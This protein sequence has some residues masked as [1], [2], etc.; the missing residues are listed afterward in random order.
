MYRIFLFVFITILPL[1][2]F[3]EGDYLSRRDGFL[4]IWSSIRRSCDNGANQ[5]FS[6][7]K[8][9][10]QGYEEISYA[11]SRG[12]LDDVEMFDPDSYLNMEDAL[13]WLFR[14]RNVRDDLFF[15][16]RQNIGGM[17]GEYP[18]TEFRD[19]FKSMHLTQ[20]ELLDLSRKLDK[21]LMEQVHL[22]SYY[23]DDFHG[24]GTAFGETFDMYEISA[25]HR[26]LPHNTMVKV[27]N[28]DN[29]KSV[30]VR[31]NDRGPYVDG[32]NMDLSLAAFEKIAPLGQGV[33]KATFQR[34]GDESFVD[35]CLD[36]V[37]RFQK[38]ITRNVRFHRGVP[39]T[40][41]TGQK[42]SLGANKHFV[43][44]KIIYPDG[45]EARVQDFVFPDERFHFTPSMIGEY[46][47]M[48][49][50]KEGRIREFRMEVSRCG[51]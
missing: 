14:S 41:S 22:V 12:I 10:D 4:L 48:I 28:A 30:V 13:L 20:N 34:L 44:R 47:F 51:G 45:Y 38:R 3:A 16:R 29:G 33:I 40:W 2:V 50:T 37:R 1:T 5:V 32:R 6:D 46:I 19:D 43:V 39:H 7:V 35:S 18:I 36:E 9:G 31:I 26:S 11:A 21:L 25:A 23:A 17:L 15:M 8:P 24:N 49:G 27:T 42:L